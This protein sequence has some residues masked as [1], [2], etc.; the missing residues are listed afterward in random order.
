MKF[1]IAFFAGA[2]LMLLVGAVADSVWRVVEVRGEFEKVGVYESEMSG[3]TPE[4][5]CYVA[6]TNTVTGLT[7]VFYIPQQTN[8]KLRTRA[9]QP[10]SQESYIL[11]VSRR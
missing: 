4:G 3:I 1:L 2:A 6:V 8:G 10:T 11:E 5:E 7:E 9:L